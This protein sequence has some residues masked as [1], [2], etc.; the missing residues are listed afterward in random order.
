MSTVITLHYMN[1]SGADATRTINRTITPD[2]STT[3]ATSAVSTYQRNV[4]VGNTTHVFQGWQDADGAEVT[5]PLTITYD[6][7]AAAAESSSDGK[8]H[9]DYT[10]VYEAH[11]PITITL[12]FEG[13]MHP[14]GS[15]T[16]A[17]TSNS[18]SWAGGWNFTKK[19]LESTTGLTEGKSFGYCGYTYTYTGQWTDQDGNVID[20][21]SSIQLKHNEGESS[22]N[23]YY[24]T[25]DTT[26]TF[27]PV[28]EKVMNHG[29][30]YYYIDNVSTG[31]GSWSNADAFEY[32]SE[33]GSLTHTFSNPEDKTPVAHYEF[34]NWKDFDH[35]KTYAAGDSFTYTVDSGLPEGTVTTY[36]IYA[37]WQPSVTVV[38]H[39]ADGS[40]L[41][42]EES[43]DSDIDVYNTYEQG[44]DADGNQFEGWYDADG[45][46]ISEGTAYELP[47]VTY[48]N[49]TATSY[50]VYARYYPAITV[51]TTG[52]EYTYDGQAHG[53]TVEATIQ[54]TDND[55]YSDYTVEASS[56]ATATDVA[57]GTVD[58]TADQITVTNA[59]GPV[60][61][62]KLKITYVDGTIVINPAP[63]VITT[64]SGTKVFDGTA[65][66]APGS[67]SGLVNGETA[68][69]NTT[70]SQTA[71]GSS[72]NTYNMAWNGTAKASN[73]VIQSETLG[74]LTVTAAPPV[75]VTPTPGGTTPT[76]V[77]PTPTTTTPATPTTAAPTAIVGNPTPQSSGLATTIADDGNPLSGALGSWSL[78]DLICTI[79]T[80]LICLLLLIF[81]LG[82]T[83]KNEEDDEPTRSQSGAYAYA[84]G[85]QQAG[86]PED[87]DE[88]TK[89]KRRRVL[90]VLSLIPAIAA[91]IL[92]LITQ[93]FTQPMAIFDKWSIV[94]LIIVI[95]QVILAI[96]SHRKKDED[97]DDDEQASSG[98]TA[99]AT[100]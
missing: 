27:V 48:E 33:F 18:I 67:V 62:S 30:D 1:S 12:N 10:A 13:V 51:V 4:S 42:T 32:R 92:L 43:F 80:A 14:D 82:R 66:T 97:E 21:S 19:K 78:F 7:A 75:P 39:D 93:D 90:R 94:F 55:D 60:D 79:L 49:G 87:Q 31:S 74:T 91:I 99:P 2:G 89:I 17:S 68:A 8:A 16:S 15:I 81:G 47:A 22:G 63:L 76:P 37:M 50:D 57:D 85:A 34:V 53:A 58:A 70:G 61:L 36:T 40:V 6:E 65:L 54:T 72:T 86:Q 59:Q 45:N 44:T 9:L 38:Y 25:E 3:I 28:Y 56:T 64:Q 88:Q 35:S 29:L 5:F 52:G 100:A 41:D 98:S 71:V 96:A 77:T 20:T 95:I 24:L 84:G 73:Y 23:V 11:D 69:V 83:K 26:L 46:R